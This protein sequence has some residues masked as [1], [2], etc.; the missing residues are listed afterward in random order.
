MAH[1]YTLQ[2]TAGPDYDAKT[3][4]V[5]AVNTADPLCFESK[6]MSLELNVRIQVC[7]P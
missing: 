1:N 2:V 6:A 7:G 4:K 3:H 5:V